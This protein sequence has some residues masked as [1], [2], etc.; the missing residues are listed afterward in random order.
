MG[1]LTRAAIS[2]SLK[3]GGLTGLP[4]IRLLLQGPSGRPWKVR[5]PRHPTG[6]FLKD[7]QVPEDAGKGWYARLRVNCCCEQLLHSIQEGRAR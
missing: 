1:I 5:N 2:I 6:G 3:L 7:T 4:A